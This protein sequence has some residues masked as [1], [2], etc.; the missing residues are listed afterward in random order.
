MADREQILEHLSRYL[1]AYGSSLNVIP[2]ETWV[3][4]DAL[5]L[6]KAPEPRLLTLDEINALPDHTV[7]WQEARI[8]WSAWELNPLKE[9]GVEYEIAPVEKQGTVISDTS[10]TTVIDDDLLTANDGVQLRFWSA[11][12]TDEQRKAVSW[13]G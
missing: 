5:E 7:L 1:L 4:K 12:P 9:F 6:L 3:L 13:D 11:R 10:G 8:D 2:I